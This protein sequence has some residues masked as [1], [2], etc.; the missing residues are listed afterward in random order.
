MFG[1]RFSK[2]YGSEPNETWLATI[3]RLSDDEVKQALKNLAETGGA[4][5]PTLGEFVAATKPPKQET[6]SPRYLGANP[7]NYTEQRIK[8]LLPKPNKT[9]RDMDALRKALRGEA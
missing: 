9:V 2:E 7:I 4:F 8:G 3:A 6:G 5:P 1:G